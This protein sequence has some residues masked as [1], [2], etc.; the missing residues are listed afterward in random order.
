M[1]FLKFS[2]DKPDNIAARSR[3]YLQ[4]VLHGHF[5]EKGF[6]NCL[7]GLGISD[8][9]EMDRA[10]HSPHG[11]REGG[12]RTSQNCC[13]FKANP[14]ILNFTVPENKASFPTIRILEFI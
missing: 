7:R 13:L 11:C 3:R 4:E 5:G 9:E 12:G 14:Q 6:V 2:R 10:I 1:A 8:I